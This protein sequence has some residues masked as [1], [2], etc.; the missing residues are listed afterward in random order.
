M[1]KGDSD[2]LSGKILIG[3]PGPFDTTCF[4]AQQAIEKYCKALIA[5]R[6][7]EI[8]RIHN[9]VELHR[10]AKRLAPALD[11]DDIDF[12]KLTTYAVQERY[13]ADFWPDREEAAEALAMADRVRIAILKALPAKA[14]PQE[15]PTEDA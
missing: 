3:G 13:A 9:L 2:R 4:H 7:S 1:A 6:G 8:P 15:L 11:L 10:V 5:H 14:H 12:L